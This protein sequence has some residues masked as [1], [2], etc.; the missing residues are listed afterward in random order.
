MEAGWPCSGPLLRMAEE[1]AR[2]LLPGKTHVKTDQ[3]GSPAALSGEESGWIIIP[4][5]WYFYLSAPTMEIRGVLGIWRARLGWTSW[6]HDCGQGA[7]RL[8]GSCP[9]LSECWCPLP[10]PHNA[11]M[12]GFQVW[13]FA[14]P[15]SRFGSA[16]QSLD[17]YLSL[18]QF[19]HLS[20]DSHDSFLPLGRHKMRSEWRKF[21]ENLKHHWDTRGTCFVAKPCPGLQAKP[22]CLSGGAVA[23]LSSISWTLCFLQGVVEVLSAVHTQTHH[24]VLSTSLLAMSLLPFTPTCL[25]CLGTSWG[26]WAIPVQARCLTACMSP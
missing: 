24:A 3:R 13:A 2:K 22:Q 11:G 7:W 21:L 26:E 5:T 8:Q 12:K 16:S 15:D 1:A 18:V 20:D 10:G 25:S 23:G 9:Y 14:T 4:D 19:P 17:P 6:P